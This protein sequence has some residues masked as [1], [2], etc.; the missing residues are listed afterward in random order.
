LVTPTGAAILAQF[1]ESFGPMRGLETRRIGYGLG[2]RENKAR[3]NVLRAVLCEAASTPVSGNDW[4]TDTVAI[5]E[6]NLDDI[7][8]EILGHFVELA[9]GAG[10]LDVYHTPIQ[11]KKSRP[12]VLLTVLCP[13][14]DADRFTELML[15]ETTALGVRRTLAERRKLRR[16][17]RL[18]RTRYGDVAVKCA[19]LNGELIQAA[20]EYESC[21]KVAAQA[22][23][24]VKHVYEAALR[25]HSNPPGL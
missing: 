14:D 11:M 15:R 1:V 21:R 16:E 23:V 12:G 19:T 4:E 6:T 5:L 25:A 9:L 18:L 22:G 17:S 3:P 13:A 8:A 7:N 2:S 10:A 20:P 24:P